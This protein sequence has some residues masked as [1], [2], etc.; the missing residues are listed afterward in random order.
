[1]RYYLSYTYTIVQVLVMVLIPTLQIV[2]SLIASFAA[3]MLN[4]SGLLILAASLLEISAVR[5]ISQGNYK[6]M[7]V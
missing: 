2:S 6:H 4:L 5:E 7:H 3:H 1:M